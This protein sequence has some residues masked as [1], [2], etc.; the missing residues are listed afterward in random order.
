MNKKNRGA[1]YITLA[2]A[3]R[4]CQYS[5]EYLS[6]RARQGKLR[7]AKVGRNWVTTPEWLKEYLDYCQKLKEKTKY[8]TQSVPI[9]ETA[10]Q[11]IRKPEIKSDFWNLFLLGQKNSL[12]KAIFY[13]IVPFKLSVLGFVKIFKEFPNS[14][15]EISRFINVITREGIEIRLKPIIAGL[16]VMAS[17]F[18]VLMTT[19]ADIRVGIGENLD[20]GADKALVLS[21]GVYRNIASTIPSADDIKNAIVLGSNNYRDISENGSLIWNEIFG[22]W[23]GIKSFGFLK[24]GVNVASL[25]LEKTS[26]NSLAILE[27][28]IDAMPEKSAKLGYII[29]KTR[30]QAQLK[31]LALASNA[32]E[33]IVKLISSSGRKIA[34]LPKSISNLAKNIFDVENRDNTAFNKITFFVKNSSLGIENK[35]LQLREGAIFSFSNFGKSLSSGSGKIVEAIGKVNEKISQ[36]VFGDSPSTSSPLIIIRNNQTIGATQQTESIKEVSKVVQPIRE[37]TKTTKQVEK[38]TEITRITEVIRPVDYTSDLS[39]LELK[40]LAQIESTK[41][42]LLQNIPSPGGSFTYIS[43]PNAPIQR[44]DSIGD[45]VVTDSFRVT[46]TATS[47]FANGIS[48]SSGCFLMPNGQ[49]AGAGSGSGSGTVNSGVIGQIPYYAADGTSVSATSSLFFAV[50]ENVGVGTTSPFAKL[51]VNGSAG[52]TAPLFAVASSSADYSSSAAQAQHQRQL[53]AS[54]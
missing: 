13:L 11:P 35:I 34:G 6:L 7:S 52:G 30:N 44:L 47:T 31:S 9:G 50:S 10:P 43:A 16:I 39:A 24:E 12:K 5:Q 28:T 17:V 49:C 20:R 3:S 2:E 38:V 26:K 8:E 19:R 14:I 53:M 1:N 32:E 48:I 42:Y 36:F 41:N 51:S 27:K 37:V 4:Y 46:G 45:L 40:L 15:G 21:R 33:K 54:F 18:G 23:K 22:G 25:F 29:S